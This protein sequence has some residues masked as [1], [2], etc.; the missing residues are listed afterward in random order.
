MTPVAHGPYRFF[1]GGS[2]LEMAV[3]RNLLECHA[4]GMFCDHRL[5]WGARASAYRREIAVAFGRGETPVLIELVDDLG[6]AARG[7]VLVDHHQERAGS[8][9]PTSLEQVFALLKLDAALWGRRHA[10]VAANDR[11]HVNELLACGAGLD[12]IRA[13]READRRAQGITRREER[14][15]AEAVRK[16]RRFVKDRLTVVRI[17]HNKASAV[18]DRMHPA[19]GGRGYE[20]LIVASRVQRRKPGELNVFG[21]GPVVLK[22]H[23]RFPGGWIGGALPKHGFWGRSSTSIRPVEDYAKWLLQN[24]HMDK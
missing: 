21:P 11:G 5:A 8:S 20:V 24:K 12:E 2:D 16:A 14:Q 17:P 1:L 9:S 19:L 13:I 4:P 15:A 23:H 10:L 22:L 3:I 18:C 6:V 7:A